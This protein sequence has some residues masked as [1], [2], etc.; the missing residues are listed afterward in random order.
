MNT[1]HYVSLSTMFIATIGLGICGCSLNA[2]VSQ[3]QQAEQ[4][5][6]TQEEL[7]QGTWQAD[8]TFPDWQKSVDDT[9]ALNSMYSFKGFKDQGVIYVEPSEDITH[10]ELFVNNKKISTDNIKAGETNKI[11]ISDKTID[12]INTLQITG[13][14]PND[15]NN[16]VK[17]H[18]PYP[19]VL[20]GYAPEDVGIEPSVFDTISDIVTSDINHGFTSAQ[21]AVIKDG[22]LIYQNAWGKTDSYNQDGTA[23][24]TAPDVTNDTLY[25]LASN[26]KMYAVNY[27]IQYLVTHD[28]FNLDSKIVDIIGQKFAD[29]TINITYKKGEN[30]SLEDNKKWKQELTVRDILRHQAGFP[31]DPQYHNDAFDQSEQKPNPAVT[32]VLYSGSDGTSETKEKTLESICKTPLMY[33]PGTKTVYSDVDYMLLGLIVEKTTGQNLN[34]FLS[35]I[36]WKP[37]DLTHITYNPLEHGFSPDDCAATELN[38]NTRDGA[39]KFSGVRTKTLQGQVHDEKA[40]YAMGGISG[41]AG[42]FANAT[43]L[44]KLANVMLTGGWDT[45]KFFSQDT[46]DTFTAPKKEDTASA[47]WGLGWWREASNSRAW[48]FGTQSSSN[49]IGHQGWTGTLT[50]INPEQNLVVVFLTNKINSPVT[51]KEKNP[52]S[53]NGNNYV[54]STLGVVPELLQMGFSTNKTDLQKTMGSLLPEMAQDKS[55]LLAKAEEK[56]NLDA[57]HPLVQSTYAVYEAMV[58]HV[59]KT[60]DK[61]ELDLC[62]K[63][64]ENLN[65]DRDSD[66]YQALSDR[67]SHLK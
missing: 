34:D 47:R 36:F 28:K 50:M 45:H 17:V 44:A 41:H 22:K 8:I 24:T 39:I 13:I 60:K 65:T 10:F 49:T 14:S 43:D 55:K 54:S 40:F 67:L 58:T 61:E 29:D 19:T 59:E 3:T 26:T 48:Y 21:M 38:G 23:N 7:P 57:S 20:T 63:T 37:M 31:A 27:A 1:M 6:V 32:N 2:P 64:L 51:N 42:L 56:E 25:D 16:T 53:F 9:L 4:A 12:G 15:K 46:I 66:E 18:I 62:T 5:N 35:T 52:N 11:D 33:K 30:P